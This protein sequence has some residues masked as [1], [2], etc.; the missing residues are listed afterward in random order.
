MQRSTSR[1]LS[2]LGAISAAFLLLVGCAASPAAP[3]PSGDANASSAPKAGA[4]PESV[5]ASTPAGAQGTAVLTFADTTYSAT[6]QFCSL[7]ESGD[8]LFHGSAYDGDGNEVG[9][10]EGDFVGLTDIPNGEARIDFGATSKLQST[11]EFVA[12]GSP[13]GAIAI[14]DFSATELIVAGSAWQADGTQLPP[15]TLVVS[16][17]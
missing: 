12:I 10:L 8:A 15:A 6:L 9:Y 14:A 13:G 1:S 2:S 16:C 4:T 17:P 3:S 7:Y 11:D 5:E